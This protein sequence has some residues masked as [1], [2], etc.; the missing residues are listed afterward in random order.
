M[1]VAILYGSQQCD[2][3]LCKHSKEDGRSQN[4]RDEENS[5]E[6]KKNPRELKSEQRRTEKF[7]S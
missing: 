1:E 3:L 7:M 2:C 5:V 4:N 6:K